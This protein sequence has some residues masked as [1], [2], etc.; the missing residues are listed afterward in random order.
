MNFGEYV[1]KALGV[2]LP[3]EYVR[4]MEKYG[5]KLPANPV[6]QKSW[7]AGLGDADFVI[8]TTLA[9]RSTV[10]GFS[11]ENVA[12][13][14]LGKKTVEVNR[15]YEELDVYILLNIRDGRVLSVDPLGVI[16][17]VADGFDDWIGPALLRATF[18]ER[19]E[20]TLTVI[21]FENEARAAEARE[22]LWDL[23]RRGSIDLDDV[24]VVVKEPDGTTRYQQQ[25]KRSKKGVVIGSITGLIVGSILFTPLVG[26]AIG[27][28]A[29]AVSASLTEMEMGIDG[30]FVKELARKFTPGC[31]AL[32]TLV[33]KADPEQV[34]ETFFGFGGKVLVN[35]MSK[36]REAAI[37]AILDAKE[38]CIEL[39]S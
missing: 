2:R 17:S 10:P 35:S 5:R 15:V 19:Y 27:A 36:N 20:S 13:G 9:F 18:K 22:K 1:G 3:E 12:I 28:L 8:G 29:A 23:Q 34:G 31:S 25:P 39:T 37:Q 24:V 16:E 6:M 32:F 30:Q 38:G 4:F 33:R 26:T 7:V 21:L 11:M 14:Y